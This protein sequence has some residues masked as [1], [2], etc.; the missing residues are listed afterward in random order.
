MPPNREGR[1]S[2]VSRHPSP[3]AEPLHV[4][5][6]GGAGFIGSH[7]VDLLLERPEID[8]TV[9]DKLT[10]AGS[11]DNLAGHRHDDRFRF[12][13]GDVAEPEAVRGL[14]RGSDRVIHA[15]AESTRS[16]W[17]SATSATAGA[18]LSVTR[19]TSGGICRREARGC[20]RIICLHRMTQ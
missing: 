19:P 9:L 2:R 4:L 16:T 3:V 1:L 10:Y 20:S 15:A 18:T 14:V 11:L 6:T 17:S 5:L 8:V 12:V 7:L 13:R